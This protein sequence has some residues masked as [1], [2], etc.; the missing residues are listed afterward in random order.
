MEQE[1][2]GTIQK[3]KLLFVIN[4]L[5]AGGAEKALVSLL[6]TLDYSRF[7]VDLYLFRAEGIFMAD[8]PAEVRVLETPKLYP[9]FD[10][11]IAKA[12]QYSLSRL[13][14]RLAW[15]RLR[16]GLVHK[17]G[18]RR[19]LVDQ[20]SWPFL[21]GALPKL[22]GHYDAAISGLEKRPNYFIIEK[23]S[24]K[25]KIGMIQNDYDSLGMDPDF[26]R[27]YFEKFDR[28]FT[29]SEQCEAILKMRFPSIREKFGVMYNIVSPAAVRRLSLQ[30]AGFEKKGIMLVSIGRLNVQKGFDLAIEACRLLLDQ[31]FDLYWHILGEGEERPALEEKIA[32][33]GLQGRFILEGVRKNPFPYVKMADIYV[34]P[35]RFEGKS[36]AIDEVK[37]LGKPIVVTDFPSV[38]DQIENGKNG[39]ITAFAPQALADGIARVL[40]NPDLAE[41]LA[42][43]LETEKLGT[44]GEIDKLYAAIDR[45]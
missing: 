3:K 23:V 32:A 18:K 6:Q 20:Y 13:N 10:M 26:D 35:S 41:H 37:I 42:K 43:N 31:G 7:D 11:P 21:S 16:F 33:L 44:S 39:I 9:L 45:T 14:F 34:Q 28:I 4:N 8:I 38:L 17:S 36:V 27:P 12:L 5:N 22:A 40:R 2:T 25:V 24:A 30:P 15:L 1:N 29:V 19:S